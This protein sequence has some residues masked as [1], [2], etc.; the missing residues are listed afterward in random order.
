MS[1]YI[2]FLTAALLNPAAD[3]IIQ[4]STSVHYGKRASNWTILHPHFSPLISTHLYNRSHQIPVDINAKF[5]TVYEFNLGGCN[6]NFY[7]LPT[8][9]IFNGNVY[10]WETRIEHDHMADLYEPLEGFIL[11]NGKRIEIKAGPKPRVNVEVVWPQYEDK[12]Q[13]KFDAMFVYDCQSDYDDYTYR[14]GDYSVAGGT[15]LI[16]EF[17]YAY[18]YDSI[19][20][21][22]F[23]LIADI[24]KDNNQY[25]PKELIADKLL[26][27]RTKLWKEYRAEIRT[28]PNSTD[29]AFKFFPSRP[30]KQYTIYIRNFK[31]TQANENP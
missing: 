9:K 11:V 31:I 30:A 29:I 6:I 15:K 24:Y 25:Q 27:P 14:S 23:T 3:P 10:F 1:Y 7:Q 18:S 16:V 2:W 17:E 19:T 12:G 13:M 26:I 8:I 21:A 22:N 28:P 20:A 4:S 5:G